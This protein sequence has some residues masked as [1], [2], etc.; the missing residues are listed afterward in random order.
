MKNF[1]TILTVLMLSVIPL[2]AQLDIQAG[3]ESIYS[4]KGEEEV[5]PIVVDAQSSYQLLGS[6]QGWGESLEYNLT[7]YQTLAFKF[8]YDSLDAGKEVAIRF[9]TNGSTNLVK[10]TLPEEDTTHVEKINLPDYAN[11]EDSVFVGGIVFYNG[12]THWS[13]SYDAPSTQAITIDYVA[14]KERIDLPEGY[15]SIYS[16]NEGDEEMA[17]LT[18]DSATTYQFLGEAQGWGESLEYD[19]SNYE[20]LAVKMTYDAENAGKEVAIRFSAN[21]EAYR[22]DV[23]LP[24]EGTSHIEEIPLADYAD[25]KGNVLV[26]GILF[27][28]GSSHWSFSYTNPV[29][30]AAKVEYLALKTIPA[31]ELAIEA[32][33]EGL[34]QT[35]PFT[36]S[37]QLIPVFTPANTTNQKVSWSS[38]D[39]N[40][41]TV[42]ENGVV[43]ALSV[44]GDVTITAIA[45]DDESIT[46]EYIITIV[47]SAVAVTGVSIAGEASVKIGFETMLEHE[48]QPENASVKRVTWSSSDT[49]IAKVNEEGIITTLEP[50]EVSISATTEDG[51]FTDACNLT[52]EGYIEIPTGYVSLYSLD[53]TVEDTVYGLDSLTSA[54]GAV[55]PGLFSSDENS[56][57]GT[58]W[59]WN[60]ADRNC[61]VSPYSELVVS[62]NFK[63]EDIGKTFLFRYAF[64]TAD[65]SVIT[66]R[67]VTIESEYQLLTIDLDNDS[68]DVDDLKLLGALKFRN[69]SEKVEFVVDYVALKKSNLSSEARLSGIQLEGMGLFGFDADNYNYEF[70]VKVSELTITATPMDETADVQ[71]SNDGD[72]QLSSSEPT[73]VVITVTAEDG[74]EKVYTLSISAS[75]SVNG[76]DKLG[77]KVFPTYSNGTF[78]IQME[79]L[80]GKVSVYNIA[81]S[82]IMYKELYDVNEKITLSPGMYLIKLE[83]NGVSKITKVVCFH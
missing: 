7:D 3:Y 53:Y 16:V 37:T 75:T 60:K 45:D 67:E 66:N 79:K 34:A 55:V 44:P 42:D 18:V 61:D 20:S 36:I 25:G 22:V 15:V 6:A 28:N 38:S 8:T 62:T 33:D 70:G 68:T 50:G 78:N 12:A 46:A 65:A 39:E 59:H 27:Y 80:P 24:E 57:L 41:A 31:E 69:S 26:G 23:T 54:P 74:T 4:L 13:F 21:G 71:I 29:T 76:V 81:G 30:A 49:T 64:S 48:V 40:M 2:F 52:V 73:E 10:I 11:E 77:M 51:G 5:A 9:S 35:L 47:G 83:S 82:R 58:T 63:K 17:P 43:K 72:I 32:E 14:V 1:F 56:L 19:F